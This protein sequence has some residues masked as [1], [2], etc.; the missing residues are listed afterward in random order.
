[1]VDAAPE[2]GWINLEG[3]APSTE[4][5]HVPMTFWDGG[6]RRSRADASAPPNLQGE[7]QNQA[8]LVGGSWLQ[9][10]GVRDEE[11]FAW[12]AGEALP[13]WQF[14]NFGT[15]GYGTL[16]AA[17]S[18][19]VALREGRIAPDLIIYAF[20]TFHGMRNVQTFD[21]VDGLRDRSGQRL[22]PPRAAFRGGRIVRHPP[23]SSL[24][25]W[26]LEGVSAAV[27]TLHE[28]VAR[29]SLRERD[30][31]VAPITRRL[32][33]DLDEFSRANGA[34]FAVMTLFGEHD[35]PGYEAH[36]LRRGIESF[37]CR[38]PGDPY[39]AALRVGGNG[40]PNGIVH[41]YWAECLTRWIRANAV[42]PANEH[43]DRLPG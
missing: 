24:A 9:G 39:A 10:Y 21:W 17:L 26:P 31:W 5:G 12:K 15:G 25:N 34:R 43:P 14:E 23:G 35:F 32:F 2:L 18:A 28:S 22:I 16:Q 41:S 4:A 27:R 1:V 40:H 11:T 38:Y 3:T 19:E 13:S 42:E 36:L 33:Q 7:A 37:D 6:R 20:A 30:A 8:V 29:A